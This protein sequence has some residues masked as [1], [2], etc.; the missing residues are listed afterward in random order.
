MNWTRGLTRKVAKI[1]LLGPISPRM[2]AAY[3][4][5]LRTLGLLRRRKQLDSD[6]IRTI[7]VSH[8]YSSIGDLVLL[9]PLFER[10][11][12]EWPDALIDVAVGDK[13]ADLLSEVGGLRNVFLCKSDTG[14]NPLIRSY[15]RVIRYLRQYRRNIM[16][17]DY[18]L[19]IAPRWGSIDTWAAVYLA[20]LTGAPRRIGYSATVDNGD[21]NVDILLTNAALGGSGEHESVR[22][23]KLL[24]RC[25]LA[26]YRIEDEALVNQ[27]IRS[28]Q[29]LAQTRAAMP[30]QAP[31][32]VSVARPSAEYAVVSPGATAS[33]RVWPSESMIKTMEDLHRR[34]GLIFYIVGSRSDEGL[35]EQLMRPTTGFSMALAGKTNVQQLLH[36]LYRAQLF[37]GMDS[38]TAHLAGAVGIPTIVISPFPSSCKIDHPNSPRRF[39]PCGP[40]V[41]VLQPEH[42]L[43][44]CNPTCSFSAS[45]CIGQ[46]SPEQVVRA[47][48]DFSDQRI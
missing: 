24:S 42:P 18:D 46:I 48:E 41:V 21:W 38:G 14:V 29:A 33:F 25:G 16:R 23:V 10:I 28:L 15:R 34:T 37:I 27:P 9:I 45:H 2:F 44:P 36:L 19:A 31:D 22:N 17:F 13:V 6:H 7:F 39:R 47:A 3:V 11:R 35:C 4:A 5:S 12:V 30:I 20:Y 8:P 26:E 32:D 43:P 40:K 1:I